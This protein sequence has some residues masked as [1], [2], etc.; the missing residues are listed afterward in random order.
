MTQLASML[1]FLEI[2]LA[3]EAADLVKVV[4]LALFELEAGTEASNPTGED[5]L[6]LRTP[7]PP[8]AP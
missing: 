8:S 6:P 1:P 7:R 3:N 2:I 5:G 4:N